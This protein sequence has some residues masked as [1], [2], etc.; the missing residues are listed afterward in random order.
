M[1][2]AICHLNHLER[3]DGELDKT[4][5]RQNVI[6]SKRTSDKNKKV[7]SAFVIKGKN[8]YHFKKCNLSF[9]HEINTTF[10][11]SLLL[12]DQFNLFVVIFVLLPTFSWTINI[13]NVRKGS[14]SYLTFQYILHSLA[15]FV[16]LKICP[17]NCRCM[18][19]TQLRFHT[20]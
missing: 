7:S 9:F 15:F 1:Q 8:N 19:S 5:Y 16:Y 13:I 6:S 2:L 14:V 18:Q 4:S 10:K 11:S 12:L 20:F 3:V 17:P